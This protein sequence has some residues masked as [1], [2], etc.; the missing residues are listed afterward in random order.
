MGSN[1]IRLTD[2]K[3]MLELRQ[4]L[5]DDFNDMLIKRIRNREVMPLIAIIHQEKKMPYAIDLINLLGNRFSF[6]RLHSPLF[7]VSVASG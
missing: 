2:R 1:V 3:Y 4:R 5:R 7:V 6:C